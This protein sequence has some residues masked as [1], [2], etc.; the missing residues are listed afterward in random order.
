M[1]T[2]ILKRMTKN[3]VAILLLLPGALLIDRYGE[4][5]EELTKKLK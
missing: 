1:T 2:V 3:I 5:E 4:E